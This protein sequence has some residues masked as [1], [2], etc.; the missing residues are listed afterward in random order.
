MH[1][2]FVTGTLLWIRSESL[3]IPCQEVYQFIVPRS[4]EKLPM[5]TTSVLSIEKPVGIQSEA[6]VGP[7]LRRSSAGPCCQALCHSQQAYTKRRLI[8]INKI[9]D[10]REDNE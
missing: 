2:Q 6:T 1:L 3:D 7:E 5:M 10:N 4:S 8:Y 9:E